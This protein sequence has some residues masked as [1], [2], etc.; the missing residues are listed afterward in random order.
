M[1]STQSPFGSLPLE[2]KL[3]ILENVIPKYTLPEKIR[4]NGA[5]V[6]RA[7]RDQVPRLVLSCQMIRGI[8]KDMRRII[9]VSHDSRVL[10]TFDLKRDTL[11]IRNMRLPR[12]EVGG[13]AEMLPIRRII[14]RINTPAIPTGVQ[15]TSHR[16]Y[17]ILHQLLYPDH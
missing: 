9:A 16:K 4:A 5:V 17:P 12:F 10:F 13:K 8:I 6:A 2:L 3:E 11:L 14:T 15:P 1:G 7:E